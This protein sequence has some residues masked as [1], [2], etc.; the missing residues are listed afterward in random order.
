MDTSSNKLGRLHR[1]PG[2]GWERE[3]SKEKL[4][5]FLIVAQNNAIRT[6]YSKAKTDNILQN[7]KYRSC[8]DR[9]E[10]VNHM[11]SKCT[12]LAQ[13]EFKTRHDWVRK[14]IHWELC[15][16]LK[17]DHT[18]KMVYVQTRIHPREW[19]SLRIL[20]RVLET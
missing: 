16:R 2:H 14:V 15:K 10:T 12:K 18:T 17:S 1:R 4:E 9:N 8:W 11:I 20:R 7:C 3:N 13:K 5:S 6:N 19:A